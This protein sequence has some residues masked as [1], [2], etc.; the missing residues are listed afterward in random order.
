LDTLWDR[1]LHQLASRI[2]AEDIEEWLQP[3]QFLDCQNSRMR[4]LVPQDVFIDWIQDNYLGEIQLA[5]EELG[6]GQTQVA[7]L[8]DADLARTASGPN[9]ALLGPKTTANGNQKLNPRYRF[10]NFVIGSSNQFAHAAARAV[11]EAPFSSYNPLYIYGHSG[12]GKT[13]LLHAVAHE[14]FARQPQLNI[15]YR[16]CEEFTNQFINSIRFNKGEAFRDRYR[17]VDVLLVDDIQFLSGKTQTQEEFFHTFNSLFERQKTIILSSDCG[18]SHIPKLES[19]LKS[20]FQWGL[21]AD[22]QAPALETRIAILKKKAAAENVDIPDDVLLFLASKIKSNV[23]ELEGALIKVIASACLSHRKINMELA[24]HCLQGIAREDSSSVSCDKIQRF[25]AD[26][27][28]LTIKDLCSRNNSK[29]VAQPRQ[30]AMYLTRHL[31]A[32][33]LPEIGLAFGNKHHSTVLYSIQKVE[34]E[35]SANPETHHLLSTFKKSLS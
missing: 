8:A 6:H 20:R 9:D 17:N 16:T 28:N 14:L 7:F 11:A 26:R 23:R 27:F 18:P 34:K 5:L 13:H 29:R 19:R 21:C 30:I 25:V 15:C 1:V 3:T 12:L 31:T 33:S 4:I 24:E 2:A 35:M 22:I 10:E 32:M